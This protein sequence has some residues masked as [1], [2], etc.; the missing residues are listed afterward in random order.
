MIR[1]HIVPA[2]LALAVGVAGC[3][4]PAA[5]PAQSSADGSATPATAPAMPAGGTGAAPFAGGAKGTPPLEGKW[6]ARGK[7]VDALNEKAEANPGDA[8]AKAEAVQ[9]NYELGRDLTDAPFNELDPRVKYRNALKYL[10]T[11][12]RMDP[13]HKE[14]QAYI[15][16]I[17]EVYTGMGMPIPQ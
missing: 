14:A 7:K 10:R 13:G 12:T 1:W 5:E 8:K 15:A 11:A 3:N 17:E 6:A 4:Q 2:L 16:K 9:A